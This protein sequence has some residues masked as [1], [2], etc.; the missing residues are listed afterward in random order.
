MTKNEVALTCSEVKCLEI[1][2]M[3]GQNDGQLTDKMK[4]KD[5]PPPLPNT[6]YGKNI[7]SWADCC[8]LSY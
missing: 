1:W 8:A 5:T 7:L 4:Q 6:A 2:K 3:S